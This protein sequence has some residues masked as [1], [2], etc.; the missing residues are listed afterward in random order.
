MGHLHLLLFFDAAEK[1][2][3]T[4]PK[5][6]VSGLFGIE[7]SHKVVGHHVELKSLATPTEASANV[8]ERTIHHRVA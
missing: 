7:R 2:V 6:G 5:V 3:K 8:D 4:K 1:E